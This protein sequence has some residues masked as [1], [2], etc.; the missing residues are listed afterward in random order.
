MTA[1]AERLQ[2]GLYHGAG[3][4]PPP[5]YRLLLVN[6]RAGTPPAAAQDA[7]HRVLA[8][9]DGTLAE[10]P[11]LYEGTEAL[12]GYGR[13]LFAHE[14]RLTD[15]P[16]PHHLAFLDQRVAA[17]PSL[18]WAREPPSNRAEADIALQL[19]GPNDAAVG[20]A[21]VEVADR[22]AADELPL[23]PVGLFSGFARPDG[24][25]W[26][27]F[28]DGVSNLPSEQ[29]P[30]AVTAMGEPA[31]MAGG[32]YMTFLRLRIDLR[33]WRALP[34]E[35]QEKLV[36]RSR[37]SGRPLDALGG[38]E[39]FRDPPET[40]SRELE[41]SHVHRAN[42][43]RASPAAPAALRI[44]RQGY[45]FLDAIAPDGPEL[46]LNFISFQ[47]DLA[48]VQHLLHLPGWLGD[49]NFGGP[50]GSPS[51]ITLADGGFYAV[52]PRAEP[53]PGACLFTKGSR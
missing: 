41:L 21:A 14:A 50:P 38:E 6:V 37:D 51:F 27:G 20:C 4:R 9:L 1:A 48:T 32:T 42:Q 52:P 7:L 46:G 49:V 5:A 36:G 44:Y 10:A 19:T 31:W 15:V 43:S 24:R 16:R 40:T 26:L 17:F 12:V 18:P 33:R 28:H 22:I 39:A 3:R 13:R 45:D 23:D 8:S 47:A 53:F 29:R 30:E 34:L 25:G 11:D 2:P 35:H